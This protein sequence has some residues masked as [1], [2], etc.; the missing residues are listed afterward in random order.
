[1]RRIAAWSMGNSCLMARFGDAISAAEAIRGCTSGH[2]A[3]SSASSNQ[4]VRMTV[5]VSRRHRRGSGEPS[6]VVPGSR[7]ASWAT[8][9]NQ[10]IHRIRPSGACKDAG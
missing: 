10:H 7:S 8:L 5:R 1:M 4:R 2:R 9:A 6:N 3:A